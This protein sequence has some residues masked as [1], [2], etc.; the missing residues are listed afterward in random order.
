MKKILIYTAFICWSRV[1]VG[2]ESMLVKS[3][4]WSRVHVGQGCMLVKSAYLQTHVV[5]ALFF[6]PNDVSLLHSLI[7]NFQL[8]TKRTLLH[9]LATTEQT[10]STIV[11]SL[12]F[13]LTFNVN[14]LGKCVK[15][16]QFLLSFCIACITFVIIA[17]LLLFSYCQN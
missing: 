11:T 2:Q 16:R 15:W 14:C 3:A 12:P 10:K 1:I 4:C 9:V 17:I 7:A 5:F 6:L 8:P 13:P